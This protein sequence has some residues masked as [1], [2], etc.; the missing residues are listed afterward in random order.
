MSTEV[1]EAEQARRYREA[2]Q[3]YLRSLPLEHFMEAVPQAT[4]RKITV[5][6]LELVYVHRPD[7]QCFNELLVQQPY[8]VKKTA[9]PTRR[10]R[11]LLQVVPD[12]MVVV[13]PEPIEA[14]GSYDVPLQPVSPFWVLEYVS[15]SNKRKDYE[16]N[17]E[18]YEHDMKVPYYLLFQPDILEMTLYRHNKRKYVSVKPN[19][20]ER[21]ALP[22]LEMEVTLLNDWVR[23]W[24]RGEL[25]PLPGDLLRERDETKQQLGQTQRQLGQTQQQLELERRRVDEEQ[26]GRQACLEEELGRLREELK[27]LRQPPNGGQ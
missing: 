19:E 13:H 20:H 4:Q 5:A 11:R 9:K 18:K 27:R 16:D 23:F 12:N 7:I 2:A 10:K 15:R 24:F 17:M 14:E 6:S 25:L 21:Y 3:A 1:P 22:E 26:K 8:P